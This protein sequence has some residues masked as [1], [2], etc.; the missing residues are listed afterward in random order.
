MENNTTKLFDGHTGRHQ[1]FGWSED[2][3]TLTALCMVCG[4]EETR[5]KEIAD[6]FMRNPEWWK[7]FTCTDCWKEEKKVGQEERLTETQERIA[8]AQSVNCAVSITAAQVQSGGC[9]GTDEKIKEAIEE[10]QSYFYEQL[11]KKR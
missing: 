3:K 8:Y 4:K 6:K 7:V 11:T 5:P 2:G 9:D 1:E 10:W